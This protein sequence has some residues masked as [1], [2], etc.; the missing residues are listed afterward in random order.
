MKKILI[1]LICVISY[2]PLCAS[3]AAE[4]SALSSS[5]YIVGFF[6]NK[7]YLQKE[8]QKSLYNPQTGER[9]KLEYIVIDRANKQK[10]VMQSIDQT[11]QSTPLTDL[12]D[13]I[14]KMIAVTEQ[15]MLKKYNDEI[16]SRHEEDN[17]SVR[18]YSS[19]WRIKDGKPNWLGF[20]PASASKA[21]A[22]KLLGDPVQM[23]RVEELQLDSFLRHNGAA[24]VAFH[25][26]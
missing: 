14:T 17:V 15:A 25:K 13:S 4:S 22:A 16:E 20:G 10:P 1:S 7:I 21:H 9:A 24:P 5:S 12:D 8:A 18:L 26:Q 3:K 11:G 19:C 23:K 6:N 2:L